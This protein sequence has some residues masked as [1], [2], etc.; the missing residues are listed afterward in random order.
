MGLLTRIR[1]LMMGLTK[2]GRT[3]TRIARKILALKTRGCLS[4]LGAST[5]TSIQ[6]SNLQINEQVYLPVK[7]QETLVHH[8]YQVS[9]QE[10]DQAFIKLP[11]SSKENPQ[12]K[13]RKEIKL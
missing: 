11:I 2:L 12:E 6:T 1:V 8:F 3:N 4:N 7:E 9:I 13:R 10:Y 5:T